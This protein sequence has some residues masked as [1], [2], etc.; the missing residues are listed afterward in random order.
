ML[1]CSLIFPLITLQTIAS[2]PGHPIL[3]RTVELIV[4]DENKVDATNPHFVHKHTGPGSS[5]QRMMLVIRWG[6]IVAVTGS[7]SAT[8]PS[9]AIWTTA[10]ADVMGMRGSRAIDIY[11]SAWGG[12]ARAV[13]ERLGICFVGQQYFGGQN[14][15][16]QYGSQHYKDGYESWIKTA[17][18]IHSNATIKSSN[19]KPE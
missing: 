16:N 7:L 13:R 12:E 5:L 14:A 15:K 3:K 4:D 10:I 19:P 17:D 18:L 6:R 9:V 1:T 2:V 11:N 8:P